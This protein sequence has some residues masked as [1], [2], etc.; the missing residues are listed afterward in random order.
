MKDKQLEHLALFTSFIG[1]LFLIIL[2][3]TTFSLELDG[4]FNVTRIL[5]GDT[6]ELATG[7]IVRLS[8]ID[9]PETGTCYAKEAKEELSKR[10]L[11]KEVYLEKDI[12]DAGKYDRLLRYIYVEDINVNAHLVEKGFVKTFHKYNTTTKRYKEFAELEQIVKEQ[13]IG[14]WSCKGEKC[15]YI[16]NKNSKIYHDPKCKAAKRMKEENRVCITREEDLQEF[17]AA[18]VC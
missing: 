3:S 13:E 11:N 8:G 17:T 5:D 12:T 9:A 18:K 7:E 1:V 14:V 2:S 4:P 16:A 6:V 15:L 10:I